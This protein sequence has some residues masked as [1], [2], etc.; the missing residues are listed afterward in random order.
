[1]PGAPT[2]E[3]QEKKPLS[4]PDTVVARLTEKGWLVVE[5]MGGKT[6]YKTRKTLEGAR[7][8]NLLAFDAPVFWPPDDQGRD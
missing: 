5:R 1:V 8:T 7:R 3:R 6:R 4:N 2:G